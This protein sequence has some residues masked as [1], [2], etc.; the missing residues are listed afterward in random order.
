DGGSQDD[1]RAH[2]EQHLRRRDDHCDSSWGRPGV[3]L[4]WTDDYPRQGFPERCFPPREGDF[5]PACRKTSAADSRSLSSAASRSFR[6][7]AVARHTLAEREP[8]CTI[9]YFGRRWRTKG[10]LE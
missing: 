3:A 7:P 5:W 6:P 2:A 9:A 10:T 1:A 8:T 4:P